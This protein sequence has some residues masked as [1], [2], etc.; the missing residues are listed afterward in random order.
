MASKSGRIAG[1]AAKIVAYFRLK[2]VRWTIADQ[3][4]ARLEA[5]WPGVRIVSLEGDERLAAELADAEVFVGW[6]FPAEHF[7]AAKRLCWIHSAS[8]GVENNLFPALVASDVV[9]TS[10]AG[11]HSVCIPEHVLG[12]LLVLARNFHEAERLRQRRE[13]NRFGVIAFNGGIR[14]LKGSKL[15]I[16]GAGAIGRSLVPMAV[17]LGMH[18]RV[19]R[20][21]ASRAVPGAEAVVPPSGLHELLAWADFVVLAVPSTPE[22]KG[23]IGEK[24]LAAMRSSA[25]LVNVARGEVVDEQAL[26]RV[27][28]AGGLAGAA[29]DVFS[30]EPLPAEHPF[31]ELPNLVLTPHVSG[32]TPG[33]F[34]KMLALFEDNLGRYL[35]GEP[36]RNVVDKR[37]GYSRC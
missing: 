33:Y 29:L 1:T 5:G 11:L 13:W 9:L 23:M 12:Q 3:D 28:A 35:G 31:W 24:E 26:A 8:A 6:D 7:A 20:R 14:E 22:T 37:L 19:M 18:V 17:G 34:D 36:L 32:Y 16:L 30:E 25:F 27:L 2:E 10:S 15:A 21:D 4:V